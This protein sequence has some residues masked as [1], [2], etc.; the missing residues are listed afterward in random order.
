MALAT[1]C[2]LKGS[3]F[4]TDQIGSNRIK[5][6]QMVQSWWSE[7]CSTLQECISTEA[8]LLNP[9]LHLWNSM[10][11]YGHFVS[12]VLSGSFGSHVATFSRWIHVII[13]CADLTKWQQWGS[14]GMKIK[15]QLLT[16]IHGL[17]EPLWKPQILMRS[18]PAA[19]W[20][21][22]PKHW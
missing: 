14:N 3:R 5:S 8:V 13:S 7:S 4:Y 12:E 17:H 10:D 19:P 9:L 1:R 20:N 15:I 11:I 21:W 22:P 16:W 2:S 6:D 18:N